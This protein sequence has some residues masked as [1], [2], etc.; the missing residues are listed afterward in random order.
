MDN[1]SERKWKYLSFA[2]MGI[3]GTGIFATQAYAATNPL[4]TIIALVTD[5]KNKVNLNLDAKVSTRASQASL[6]AL[7]GSVSGL[8]L[9][10]LDA[11]VSTRATQDSVDAMQT[12]VTG[13][14]AQT[15]GLPADPA[16]DTN[17]NTRA[18]QT[19]L[20]NLQTTAN[21]I[22]AKTDTIS[23]S[24]GGMKSVRTSLFGGSSID[25]A[26]A[27]TAFKDILPA[28]AGKTYS[29][30]ITGEGRAN[31]NNAFLSCSHSG[32]GHSLLILFGTDQKNINEGFACDR[33]QLVVFDPHSDPADSP[34]AEFFLVTQ[35]TETTDVTDQ[36]S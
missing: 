33:L 27:A 34:G 16:S 9:S 10:N 14:M 24:S 8:D 18:S 15:D 29:G 1:Y 26:D 23:P 6:D 35:Y 3:L 4:D 20:D 12:D 2:L 30:W 17:V 36:T 21:A 25:P 13:I 22:K 31:G 28:V 5:V 11:A 7:Q 19:S 32:T